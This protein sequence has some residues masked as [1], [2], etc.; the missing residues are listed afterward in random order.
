MLI[1]KQLT[2]KPA[3]PED[4][5]MTADWL[6]DPAYAGEYANIWPIT[7]QAQERNIAASADRRLYLIVGRQNQQAMGTIGFRKAFP[8]MYSELFRVVEI[9]YSVH[10]A[11]RHQGIAT[12]A[13]RILVNHIFDATPTERIQAKI[14]AGNDV[15]CRVAEAIGMRIEGTCR[16]LFFLHGRYVDMSLYAIIRG[17]WQGE[18]TYR[19]SCP[20]F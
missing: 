11:F 19:Q 3:V 12:Q 18:Q 1:G 4:A 2:L 15:S 14:V 17:D 13:G 9:W 10:P 20:E 8:E 5:E 16:N 6:S 7:K